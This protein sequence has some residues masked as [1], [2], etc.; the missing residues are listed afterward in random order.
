VSYVTWRH[1]SRLL[2]LGG[3]GGDW[4][5]AM[6]GS[7]GRTCRRGQSRPDGTHVRTRARIE[8][9]KER[10]WGAPITAEFYPAGVG[11]IR[12]GRTE[13]TP[14][15]AGV[16]TSPSRRHIWWSPGGGSA[17][18][19]ESE[20]RC[21][22]KGRHRGV[23]ARVLAQS[24]SQPVANVARFSEPFRARP[25][26]SCRSAESRAECPSRRVCLPPSVGS[27][28][29]RTLKRTDLSRKGQRRE[30]AEK[31][32][33]RS[34]SNPASKPVKLS[35]K[36][37]M[38]RR[39]ARRYTRGNWEKHRGCTE[40]TDKERRLS[41]NTRWKSK[42]KDKI[43]ARSKKRLSRSWDIPR[44]CSF[45][46]FCSRRDWFFFRGIIR[47]PI[48]R[49]A[50]RLRPCRRRRGACCCH[51]SWKRCVARVTIAKV[52]RRLDCR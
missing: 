22:R 36:T 3:R 30:V 23:R 32:F 35:R 28:R 50:L 9:E 24:I 1:V 6:F 17:R 43:S 40:A 31:Q 12:R 39:Y 33:A 25:R 47:V 16:A 51:C 29:A 4:Q 49:A 42:R 20:W 45:V 10:G 21:E 27:A 37:E 44:D 13:G 48:V 26:S 15:R 34:A 18:R 38:W 11:E 7:G 46:F 52:N 8:R 19:R 2:L 5:A 41:T 14:E